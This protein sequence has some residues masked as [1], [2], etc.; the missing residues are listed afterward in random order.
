MAKTET[1]ATGA[2][3]ASHGSLRLKVRG[4]GG[5]SALVKAMGSIARAKNP[6]VMENSVAECGSMKARISWPP[7]VAP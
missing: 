1:T 5:G 3:R 4:R 7:A 2:V 6:A